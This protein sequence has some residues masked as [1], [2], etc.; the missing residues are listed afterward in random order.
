MK[1]V[2]QAFGKLPFALVALLLGAIM[3]IA[4]SVSINGWAVT[5][6]A[7][8][9]YFPVGVGIALL[10][11][12]IALFIYDA[13]SKARDEAKGID[14][15]KVRSKDG[16]LSTSV[17]QCE[18][19]IV[20]GRIEDYAGREDIVVV[21]PCNE[22]FDD[23]V[24]DTRGA[25]GAYVD[26]AFDGQVD[27]FLKLVRDESKKKLGVGEKRQKTDGEFGV[28]FGPGR[29]IL[30]SR[31]LGRVVSVAL[32]STTTQRAGEGLAARISYLF[33]GMGEL[34]RRLSDTRLVDVVMPVMGGGHGR[35]LSPLAL[36][37]LVLAV[38]EAGRY[39]QGGG[40]R[41]KSVTIVLFK[42]DA[43]SAPEIDEQIARRALA[44]VSE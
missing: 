40:H 19:R 25:L 23:F 14:Y 18:I 24:G 10:V 34:L 38:A 3:V 2:L 5:T 43:G 13:R 1:D 7:P 32:M 21:L 8:T 29:C 17:N 16:V 37:G 44:L 33:D 31:P 41:L 42:R 39:G 9:S 4:P 36:V 22:Y 35:I 6:H 26:R 28:S 15:A 27:A 30:L 12:S 20:S 11:A